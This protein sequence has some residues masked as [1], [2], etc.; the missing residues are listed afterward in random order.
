MNSEIYREMILEHYKSPV[1]S[2]ILEDFD[3]SAKD[4]NPSC[5]DVVEIQIKFSDGV[6]K[7]VKFHGS[8]RV[9]TRTSK[10]IVSC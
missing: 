6:I 10:I 1:N 8:H 9:K 4:F 2:G 3:A 7:D 5:G